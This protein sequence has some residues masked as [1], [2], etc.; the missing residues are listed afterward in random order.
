V[1]AGEQRRSTN[2]WTAEE[3]AQLQRAFQKHGAPGQTSL[4]MQK[5]KEIHASAEF[6]IFRK[7]RREPKDLYDKVGS[8][9]LASSDWVVGCEVV[10][11]LTMQR[12]WC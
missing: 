3:T 11:Y 7:A 12:L 1:R 2:A 4:P 5:W 8:P 6:S 9:S 10:N